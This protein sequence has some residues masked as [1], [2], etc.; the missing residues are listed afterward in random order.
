MID[1]IAGVTV[2]VFPFW[3]RA[4]VLVVDTVEALLAYQHWLSWRMDRGIF[5]RR[6]Y[7]GFQVVVQVVVSFLMNQGLPFEKLGCARNPGLLSD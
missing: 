4:F 7:H 3:V 2:F 5:V 6:F 1:F